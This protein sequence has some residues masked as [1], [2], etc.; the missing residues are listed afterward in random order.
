LFRTETSEVISK[1]QSGVTLRFIASP[2][3]KGIEAGPKLLPSFPAE[4]WQIIVGLIADNIISL[5]TVGILEYRRDIFVG[6]FFFPN[7]CQ[8]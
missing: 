6:F 5:D 8:I 4:P 2:R 7:G 1:P 3:R